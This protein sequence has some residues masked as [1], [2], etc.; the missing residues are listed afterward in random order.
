MKRSICVC[1]S[2]KRRLLFSHK[3]REKER[4]GDSDK[5]GP[6]NSPPFLYIQRRARLSRIVSL[7]RTAQTAR[8]CPRR[9]TN[10]GKNSHA[11]ILA[12]DFRPPWRQGMS[13]PGQTGRATAAFPIQ[14]W[15]KGHELK[16]RK[17]FKPTTS[18]NQ[19][20]LFNLKTGPPTARRTVRVNTKRG[21][22][23]QQNWACKVPHCYTGSR[24]Q[25]NQASTSLFVEHGST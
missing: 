12:L 22:E 6:F 10:K 4:E 14:H 13:T 17:R 19:P 16:I 9:T 15:W 24:G 1:L 11:L 3:E 20:L 21:A 8:R 5:S 18:W 23:S 25:Q 2:S 7:R